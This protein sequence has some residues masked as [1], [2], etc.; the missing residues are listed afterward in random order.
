M[1]WFTE[2]TL[3]SRP[4]TK[5]EDSTNRTALDTFSVEVVSDD[6]EG[7]DEGG[8][9]DDEEDGKEEG[10]DDEEVVTKD[11]AE[12]WTVSVSSSV[13]DSEGDAVVV[14]VVVVVVGGSEG[15]S[16]VDVAWSPGIL[17]YCLGSFFLFG[18]LK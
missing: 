18:W 7:D 15:D 8:E 9:E 12:L 10:G 5:L 16:E 14:I 4:L 2:T 3:V 17:S 6:V 1:K 13:G 11:V